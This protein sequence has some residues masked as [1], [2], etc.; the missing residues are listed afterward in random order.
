MSGTF[1]ISRLSADQ[2]DHRP[3]VVPGLGVPG[4][5]VPGAAVVEG[6]AVVL[7]G[8]AAAWAG[9]ITDCTT[10]R[11]QD[12]GRRPNAA[13]APTPV[14]I[15]FKSGRRLISSDIYYAPTR[16][17]K[18]KMSAEYTLT[19]RIGQISYPSRQGFPVDS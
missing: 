16:T 15:A 8:D 14:P 12:F 11:V 18:I 6:L 13:P 7:F 5:G 2:Q 19:R 9:T 4:A 3:P 1:L 17:Q 10:G